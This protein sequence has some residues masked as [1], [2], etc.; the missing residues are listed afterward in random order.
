VKVGEWVVQHMYVCM[1]R[2][3]VY[4]CEGMLEVFEWALQQCNSHCNNT[5]ATSIM[6]W[7]L[8]QCHGHCNNVMVT[9]TQPTVAA[10]MLARKCC[11][12]CMSHEYFQD[13][14]MRHGLC[15]YIYIYIYLYMYM[16]HIYIRIYL[17]RVLT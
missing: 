5:M 14:N 7:A 8:Q 2:G 6:S 3:V 16:T 17:I 10:D 4:V 13:Q 11:S 12:I 1:S 9:A 15:I